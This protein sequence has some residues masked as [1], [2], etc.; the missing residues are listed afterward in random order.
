MHSP[1]LL[2]P[3]D[4]VVVKSIQRIVIFESEREVCSV[5][6]KKT[7]EDQVNHVEVLDL[8]YDIYPVQPLKP[9]HQLV[10]NTKFPG[11]EVDNQF[12]MLPSRK[13]QKGPAADLNPTKVMLKKAHITN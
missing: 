10:S 1:F 13:S 2:K 7:S 11:G 3:V 8:L 4:W 12:L 6:L 5:L 9:S